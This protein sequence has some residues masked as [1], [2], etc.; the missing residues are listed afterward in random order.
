M[1]YLVYAGLVYFGTHYTVALMFDYVIGMFLGLF[2]HHKFTFKLSNKLDK[3]IFFRT[4]I[5]NVI[6]FLINIIVLYILVDFY[7]NNEY[8]SQLIALIIISIGSFLFY[9][10][11]IF[12]GW[13]NDK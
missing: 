2:L 12:N 3:K 7:K 8:I 5:S 4:I 1:A 6:I 10:F 11:F 9:K 13:I